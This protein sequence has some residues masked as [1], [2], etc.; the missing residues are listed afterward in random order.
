VL[1][2]AAS[3][4]P[5]TDAALGAGSP[6]SELLAARDSLAQGIICGPWALAFSFN[7]ARHIVEQFELTSVPKS[8]VWL[9]GAANVDGN[10]IPV[11]D[12][13]TYLNPEAS[14]AAMRSHLRGQQRLLVGGLTA[15]DAGDAVAFI[16]NHLPQQLRYKRSSKKIAGLPHK[17]QELCD[18]SATDAAGQ[19][20]LEVNPERLMDALSQELS[21]L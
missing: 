15:Q 20:Y 6:P 7:W 10:I 21:T 1:D 12:L 9:L 2:A 13:A 8:P 18:G 17:L 16:F 4:A 5:V 14:A 19:L 3:P 11:V